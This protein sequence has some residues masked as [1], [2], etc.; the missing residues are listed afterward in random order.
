MRIIYAANPTSRRTGTERGPDDG[1]APEARRKYF[2]PLKTVLY[3]CAIVA[4]MATTK[5]IF[6]GDEF[7]EPAASASTVH[8]ETDASDAQ[9][10]VGPLPPVVTEPV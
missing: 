2:S 5:A 7:A 10:A 1:V 6:T 4:V 8:T 9:P 3:M